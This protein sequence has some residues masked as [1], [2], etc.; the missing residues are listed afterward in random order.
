VKAIRIG[1]WSFDHVEYDAAGDVLYLSI[2]EPR[3]SYGRE[4]PEGH[5]QLFDQETD[6][7]CGVTLISVAQ[8]LG[9]RTGEDIRVTMPARPERISTAD[10][11]L[12]LA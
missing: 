4:T 6:V 8:L 10:L 3:P 9:E 7:F 11:Q 2:G 12:A 5:V 1:Q